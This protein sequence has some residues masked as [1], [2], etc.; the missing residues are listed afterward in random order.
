MSS[1]PITTVSRHCPVVVPYE[2]LPKIARH[3]RP[4]EARKLRSLNR[5]AATAVRPEDLVLCW[6]RNLWRKH[7][8]T[9]IN[10]LLGP[11]K[12]LKCPKIIETVF[13]TLGS[14]GAETKLA[15]EPC[16]LLNHAL[17]NKH[18]NVARAIVT[19]VGN[20]LIEAWVCRGGIFSRF[21]GR[22][23]GSKAKVVKFLLENLFR[24]TH[25][26]CL[27]DTILASDAESVR[28][29]LDAGTG[30]HT[31]SDNILV[32]AMRYRRADVLKVLLDAGIP[33]LP[34]ATYSFQ[35][36]MDNI[37]DW[38]TKKEVEVAVLEMMS[39]LIRGGADTS[40]PIKGRI[41]VVWA[42]NKQHPRIA[43]IL[44]DPS[45]F[46]G[47]DASSHRL[48]FKSIFH[49]DAKLLTTLIT[50]G[51][52][53]N[54]YDGAPLFLAAALGDAAMTTLL[55]HAGAEWHRLLRDIHT[56]TT[57]VEIETSIVVLVLRFGM[58]KMGKWPLP[59]GAV[60]RKKECLV[61]E[62][63]HCERPLLPKLLAADGDPPDYACG[64]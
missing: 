56:R 27:R 36:M 63:R 15:L 51:V 17:N 48:L 32:V 46:T 18:M 43:D 55:L 20:N 3:C 13:V 40:L 24:D 31:V 34:G 5:N 33:S 9:S 6:C 62:M 11:L 50:N 58:E 22:G 35:C 41:P 59:A 25:G 39:V 30:L 52:N 54:I 7:N 14:W 26:N 28:V 42:L 44:F 64:R 4:T 57:V 19:A 1:T 53:V 60:V 8:V 49:S 37:L 38:E 10:H 21:C 29:L 61:C 16:G 2:I 47:D 12:L 45:P 23:C